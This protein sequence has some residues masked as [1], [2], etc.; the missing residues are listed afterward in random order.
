MPAFIC[1]KASVPFLLAVSN[2]VVG[3]VTGAAPGGLLRNV[4]LFCGGKLPTKRFSYKGS[5]RFQKRVQVRR[6]F[7]SGAYRHAEFF[8]KTQRNLNGSDLFLRRGRHAHTE[9]LSLLVSAGGPWD[10][11]F[12]AVKLSIPIGV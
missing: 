12:G 7:I 9:K 6:N 8:I 1:N 2:G 10:F 3:A 11:K 4:R 5:S